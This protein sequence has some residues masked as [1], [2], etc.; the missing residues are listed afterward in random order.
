MSEEKDLLPLWSVTCQHS[1]DYQASDTYLTRA[2]NE[3]EAIINA[4]RSAGDLDH[5]LSDDPLEDTDDEAFEKN[6]G[7]VEELAR[8][9]AL[10][11]HELEQD[12][13]DCCGDIWS[14]EEF[15][16]PEIGN[17]EAVL[18]ASLSSD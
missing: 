12:R 9:R 13:R 10:S 2:D 18:I 11:I 17:G 14:A 7:I 6:P 1:L 4:M 15:E 3:T 16:M 8:L 5:A